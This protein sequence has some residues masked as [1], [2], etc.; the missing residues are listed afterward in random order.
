[1][2]QKTMKL[3]C[4]MLAIFSLVAL[5]AACG[6]KDQQQPAATT[7]GSNATTKDPEN[8]APAVDRNGFIL[9]SLPETFDTEMETTKIMYWKDAENTEYEVAELSG[10]DII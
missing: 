8:N 4:L 5:L 3:L 2:K 1:M 9:D 10:S 6:E 7:D